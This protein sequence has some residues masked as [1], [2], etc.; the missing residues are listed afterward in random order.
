MLRSFR[1]ISARDETFP[2]QGVI[3]VIRS[4][5]PTANATKRR[6]GSPAQSVAVSTQAHGQSARAAKY[7][8]MNINVRLRLAPAIPT[9]RES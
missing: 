9:W 7:K 2:A 5:S 1:F 3:P 8:F 6:R 4:N